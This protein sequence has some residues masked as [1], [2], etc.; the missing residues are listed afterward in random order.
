MGIFS[1]LIPGANKK[2]AGSEQRVRALLAGLDDSSPLRLLKDIEDRLTETARIERDFGAEAAQSAF[3]QLD[4]AGNAARTA[5][6][7]KYLSS[8]DQQSSGQTEWS[9]LDSHAAELIA[10]HAAISSALLPL[11]QSEAERSRAARDTVSMFRSWALRKKLQHF[12]YQVPA[13]A[14]WQQANALLTQ[15]IAYKLE[16]ILVV[17][18]PGESA[19]TPLREYLIG[20]YFDCLPE[21][22]LLPQQQEALDRFLRTC[23]RLAFTLVPETNSTHR[24]DLMATSGPKARKDG[25]A[26]GSSIRFLSTV[27]PHEQLIKIA[28]ALASDR[29]I[30]KWLSSIALDVSVKETTFRT[31]AH[32]WSSR[33]PR[34]MAERHN[35]SRE[36]R[37]VIGFT[38]AYRMISASQELRALETEADI[39]QPA[40]LTAD[41]PLTLLQQIE[42]TGKM[43]STLS[44]EIDAAEISI[45]TWQRVDL[46]ATG[47]SATLPALLP[48]HC[49]GAL[50]AI[51]PVDDVN[52]QLGLIRRVGRDATKHPVIGIEIIDD[53]ASCA[54]AN[55]IDHEQV[56]SEGVEAAG[57]SNVIFLKK[58]GHDVLLPPG[59]F[60]SGKLVRVTQDKRSWQIRLETLLDR[61]PDYDRARFSSVA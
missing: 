6:L 34:R 25:D 33:P 47:L 9:A 40:R 51:R 59:S 22:K 28:D 53:E 52:W 31:S 36:L 42:A 39:T 55:L 56:W 54:H 37:V 15:L 8:L 35:A 10:A 26:S 46:S 43:P 1:K 60:A 18:Y 50:I 41:S 4:Q 14:L 23:E 2:P 21:G 38:G 45:E 57:W 3:I 16:Q 24:I 30:P 17:P 48:R 12:R 44:L 13:A 58:T 61:G 32:H 27:L 29:D 20:A 49:V 11:V 19:V 7:Q 5:V